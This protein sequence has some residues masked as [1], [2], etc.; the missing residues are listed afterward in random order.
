MKMWPD[1]T[2]QAVVIVASGPSAAEV[3]LS[4]AKGQAKF[5]AVKDG[6]R[7]CPWADVLYGCDHH[8]WE[9]H[10]GVP[11]FPNLRMAYDA[12]T[13]EKFRGMP[14]LKVSIKKQ[15]EEFMFDEIGNV[16]WGGNSGFHAINLVAQFGVIRIALVGFDMRVDKG[17]HFF[18]DHKYTKD[19]PSQANCTR[20]ARII[21]SQAKVLLKRGIS[22]VNCSNVSTLTAFPKMGLE[23]FLEFE[24]EK[25]A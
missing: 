18:G 5:M 1:W 11:E 24:M 2:G 21:D 22:V 20:W 8:W 23:E 9:A 7:L 17:K 19:R 10:R 4:L 6:W 16:G 12:R 14:F 3:P 15:R 25:A 13:I